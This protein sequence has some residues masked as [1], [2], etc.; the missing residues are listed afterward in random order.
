M[1]HTL[2]IAS[3]FVISLSGPS[4]LLA[5]VFQCMEG[6]R[7]CTCLI[8]A[9]LALSH[10]SAAIHMFTWNFLTLNP[11]PCLCLSPWQ[12][13][14]DSVEY[15]EENSD[16]PLKRKSPYILKRQV[17]RSSKSR[18][19]YILK[20]SA[21]YWQARHP[22]KTLGDET[23]CSMWRHDCVYFLST[24]S[25]IVLFFYFPAYVKDCMSST[26]ACQPAF[27]SFQVSVLK[28]KPEHHQNVYLFFT[29]H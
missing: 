20:R 10:Q 7:P 1:V 27:C 11:P 23:T 13:L 2:I 14:H 21:V 18:R 19:P 29:A 15:L 24:C 4:P 25:W 3:T 22:V 9:T 16:R 8:A 26:G 28:I 5:P 6:Q 12:L 17:G